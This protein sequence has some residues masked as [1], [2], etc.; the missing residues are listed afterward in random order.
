M[1]Y[2]ENSP[3]YIDLLSSFVRILIGGTQTTKQW[4]A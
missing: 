2:G 3:L 1:F 4:L